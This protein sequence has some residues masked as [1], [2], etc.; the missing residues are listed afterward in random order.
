MTLWSYVRHGWAQRAWMRWL[1]W[2]QRCRLDPMAK[3]ARTIRNHLW[4]VIN[5]IVLKVTNAGSE[6]LIA[7]DQ[8]LKKWACG[9]RN[10]E[11]FKTA[12][13]FHF[14]VLD[15]YPAGLSRL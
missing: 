10:Q 4:G 7:K 11:R 6:S 1:S 2:A 14:G 5:A 13:M 3:V 9:Y 12:I 8:K 15:L